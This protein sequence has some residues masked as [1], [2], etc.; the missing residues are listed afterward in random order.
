MNAQIVFP[1]LQPSTYTPIKLQILSISAITDNAA[2][3]EVLAT[4]STAGRTSIGICYGTNT[5]PTTADNATNY[6]GSNL[7]FT[8][9]IASGISPNQVYYVRPFVI[10]NGKTLYGEPKVFRTTNGLSTPTDGR[11][12]FVT[13]AT[14]GGKYSDTEAEFDSQIQHGYA[15]IIQTGTANVSVIVNFTNRST[16]SAAG[17]NV[18][19]NGDRFSIVATGFFIPT[20]TGTYTFT[21]EGDDAVDLHING[22][23]VARHYGGHSVGN[24]GSHTGTID[25]VAGIKYSLR[26]RMQEFTGGEGLR[27]FWRKPSETTGWFQDVNE[28][29]SY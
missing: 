2:N 16:L 7:K 13:M 25:L 23:N 15:N 24:L 4:S 29:S 26:A 10:I 28:I 20:E 1:T 11:L 12:D 19:S 21:C 5:L 9:N 14:P 18:T 22:V 3:V 27:V 6:I 17:I 8:L